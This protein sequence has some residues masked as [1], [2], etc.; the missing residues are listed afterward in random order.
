MAVNKF[1]LFVSKLFEMLGCSTKLMKQD[2]V[3]FLP[4]SDPSVVIL[5]GIKSKNAAMTLV[6]DGVVTKLLCSVDSIEGNYFCVK[7]PCPLPKYPK[8]VAKVL[9]RHSAVLM[10]VQ[11]DWKTPLGFA[12]EV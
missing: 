7:I 12:G 9:L 8:C 3:L 5:K 4:S 6:D 10:A 11:S 1:W 2:T